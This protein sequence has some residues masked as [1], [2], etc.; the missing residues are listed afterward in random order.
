MAMPLT[1]QTLS[2]PRSDPAKDPTGLPGPVGAF[3]L[4]A[5]AGGAAVLALCAALPNVGLMAAGVALAAY[6]LAAVLAGAAMARDYP[7]DR[8]GLC[9]LVTLTRL[10]LVATLVAPLWMDA[11]PSWSV[12][13]LATLAFGLDGLDGWLARRQGLTSAFGAR[14]DMEVDAALALV[15]ALNAATGAGMAPILAGVV[16]IALGLPRYAF[17][18]AGLALPWMRRALPPRFARKAVCVLQIAVLIALQVPG[19]PSGLVV[20]MVPAAAA[21]LAW[22]FIR[23]GVW[24]WKARA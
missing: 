7:H 20:V 14:F 13:A 24:L 21:A 4:A 16:V 8:L 15:L 11:G 10:G 3:A 6:G 9:N 19:L 1:D 17:L 2:P 5:V 12:L 22:S 18:A 23:D